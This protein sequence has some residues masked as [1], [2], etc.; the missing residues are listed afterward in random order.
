M[1]ILWIKT[2][3]LHPL[4]RGGDLR[5]F[6][7]LRA[8]QKSHE[9]DFCAL[10]GSAEEREGSSLS[11]LYAQKSEWV[12][13][14]LPKHGTF[15]FYVGAIRNALFSSKPYAVD[16]FYNQGWA[17]KVKQMMRETS[18]D[19]VICDFLFP[20]CSLLEFLDAARTQP[21]VLFQHNVEAKIWER[22]AACASE[23]SRFY[24]SNQAHRMWEFEKNVASKFDGVIAVS[25][26]DASI[27]QSEMKLAN[28]LGSVP[29]GVDVEYFQQTLAHELAPAELVFLGSMD[30]HANVDGVTWFLT[31]IWPMVLKSHPKT[32]VR[33]VG[34]NPSEELIQLA[35][36]MPQVEVTGT[37]DD[38][39]PYLQTAQIAIVPLRVGG[40]TRIKIFECMAAGL[41]VV[42]TKIGAEG[43]A[44]EPGTHLIHADEAE[45]FAQAVGTLLDCGATR[46]KL[47]QNALRL[48]ETDYS[49]G[50]AALAFEQHLM[51][52][53]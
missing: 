35:K 36:S 42:S 3:P 16:R 7:M 50:A 14:R 18:Y 40:G 44:L 38:V 4:N 49:W 31:T 53:I 41:P 34:R 13:H 37:V 10:V 45:E 22:R 33:I 39:R 17:T 43:L 46:Q 32:R 25:E 29:T 12:E 26:Q 2:S 1:K 24:W 19:M 30:W 52:L 11:Y 21:W 20:A 27:M 23:K 6:H 51:R 5:T 28:V 8:L 48:V 15:S 9:I 47:S